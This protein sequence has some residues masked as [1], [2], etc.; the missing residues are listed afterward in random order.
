MQLDFTQFLSQV[1]HLSGIRPIP[2]REFV[3]QYVK[4]YYLPE[5]HFENWIKEHSVS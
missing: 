1:Q 2:G 5:S 3:E 4:A